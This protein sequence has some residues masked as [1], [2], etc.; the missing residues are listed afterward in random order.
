MTDLSSSMCDYFNESGC[1]GMQPKMG[2]RLH[3]KLNT[4]A[5]PI[6]NKYC[7]GKMQRTLK[8]ELKVL[9]IVKRESVERSIH[10]VGNQCDVANL[11]PDGARNGVR[12]VLVGSFGACTS[13]RG[14]SAW[15]SRAGEGPGEGRHLVRLARARCC[16]R[17]CGD[18]A[19]GTEA[20]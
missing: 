10:R 6:A 12:L 16:Y 5:R 17:P 11:V 1:L 19:C 13:P 8:R 3:L 20:L 4:G 18:T 7:E 14:G 2:G 15:V 9:E